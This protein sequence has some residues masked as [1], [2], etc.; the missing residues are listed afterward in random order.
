MIT[1]ILSLLL[2]VTLFASILWNRDVL[3][4]YC[5]NLNLAADASGALPDEAD[6]NKDSLLQVS[7]PTFMQLEKNKE[8]ELITQVKIGYFLL[9]GF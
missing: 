9:R 6:C 7:K 3:V 2:S 1:R 8:D 4:S 5:N